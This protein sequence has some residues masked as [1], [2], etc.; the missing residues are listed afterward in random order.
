LK[1]LEEKE[2]WEYQLLCQGLSE[3]KLTL[4]QAR[5]I[6]NSSIQEVLF[7]LLVST[8]LTSKMQLLILLL[9]NRPPAKILL[10]R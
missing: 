9:T 2:P 3:N 1:Q 6:L 10:N 8:N 5:A 7:S 4:T